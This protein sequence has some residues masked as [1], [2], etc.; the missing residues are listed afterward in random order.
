MPKSFYLD[1]T[2]EKASSFVLSELGVLVSENNSNVDSSFQIV[3]IE[4][5]LDLSKEHISGAEV[6]LKLLN[7]EVYINIR[8]SAD[9][10]I[11][12]QLIAGEFIV[13]PPNIFRKFVSVDSESSFQLYSKDGSYQLL[14]RFLQDVD[15]IEA[16][17][18]HNY[19][20]LVCE[21]CQQFFVSGWVTGTGGSISIKYGNRIYMTP[22]GV[23]KERIK[24]DELF[25]LDTAGNILHVP[26]RKLDFLT[27]KL[28]DCS[29]LFLHAYKQRNAGN[30]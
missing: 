12:I 29:P 17:K 15:S 20:E 27:P 21:L 14:K 13:L 19:R 8:D 11:Q 23:Q 28:S 16:I 2:S 5:K 4:N 30:D 24:P 26:P 10:W 25:V 3:Q 9:S 6:V 7:G 1:C 22:S 18:Y